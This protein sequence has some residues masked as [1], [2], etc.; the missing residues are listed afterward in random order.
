MRGNRLLI[1]CTFFVGFGWTL[2]TVGFIS[3]F[4]LTLSNLL[5][6]TRLPRRNPVPWNAYLQHLKD[7]P[8]VLFAFSVAFVFFG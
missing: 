5:I 6:R 4:L 1:K 2:R 8:F 3:L 7:I